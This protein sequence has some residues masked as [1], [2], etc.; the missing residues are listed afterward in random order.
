MDL[1]DQGARFFAE[2]SILTTAGELEWTVAVTH[3]EGQ[4]STIPDPEGQNLAA[5][6]G[7]EQEFAEPA[8]PRGVQ[9]VTIDVRPALETT[10]MYAS[11][12]PQ[13]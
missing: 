12:P 9:T 11:P 8:G 5:K 13:F 4:V 7:W 6:G 2:R 10:Y 1:L 3:Q